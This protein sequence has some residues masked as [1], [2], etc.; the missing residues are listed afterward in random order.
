M[1]AES[2]FGALRERQF[3]LLWAGQT[4]STFGSALV[5]VAV[6]F[7]V[8]ELTGSPSALGLVFTASFVSRILLLLVGSIVADRLPRQQVMLAAD[9]LRATTQS[10][11]AAVLLLGA[12]RLWILVALFA[13]YGAGDAFFSPA[14]TGIAP[15]LVRPDRLRRANAL[16][17]LS[18]SAASV[19]GPALAGVLIATVGPGQHLA[20]ESAL[21]T[22]GATN[23]AYLSSAAISSSGRERRRRTPARCS[24]RTATRVTPE[25]RGRRA[26]RACRDPRAF[27]ARP[28]SRSIRRR[29]RSR[30]TARR[31]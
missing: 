16:M 12:A 22:S 4:A 9:V 7:A 25:R 20:S 26:S 21:P 14:A 8:V 30:R 15:D 29:T 17:G 11:V 28:R 13:L 10:L 31:R 23:D 2:Q 3:A 27:P 5:P 24:G 19:I 6:A 18:P 1:H